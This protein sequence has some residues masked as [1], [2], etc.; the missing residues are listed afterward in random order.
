MNKKQM[1]EENYSEHK[2]MTEKAHM[3][4]KTDG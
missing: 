4:K 1:N 3:N 2:E